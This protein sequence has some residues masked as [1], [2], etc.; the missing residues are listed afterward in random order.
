[1][2]SSSYQMTARD[3]RRQRTLKRNSVY[4]I[5]C[6]LLTQLATFVGKVS[7]LSSV[8]HGQILFILCATVGLTSLYFPI[9]NRRKRFTDLFV[10]FVFFSQFLVWI[11]LYTVWVYFLA[12]LRSLG[13]L[14]ALLALT[15]L[16]SNSNFL[17][18][19][20]ISILAAIMQIVV[21]YCAIVVAGQPGILKQELLYTAC[22]LPSAMFISYLAGQYFRQRLKIKKAKQAAEEARDALWGEMELAKKIQTSLLPVSP[23]V[24]NYEIAAFMKPAEMVGGDYYDIINIKGK[25]WITIGDVSGHGVPAGLFMMMVQ[26]AIRTILNK[27][28]DI[29]PSE[30][31]CDINTVVNSNLNLMSEDKYMTI[32][33]LSV[34]ENGVFKFSGLHQDILVYRKSTG[35]VEV[36]ATEGLWIG[37]IDEI[38]QLLKDNTVRLDIGDIILVYTDGIIEANLKPELRQN[39]GA[40]EPKMFGFRNL[41]NILRQYGE[42]SPAEVVQGILNKLHDY[43]CNDDV[44]IVSLK[45]RS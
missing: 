36:I 12:E 26:T 15:F 35:N 22:F 40:Q 39:P 31:L 19:A 25:D 1:M 30:L 10:N 33:V 6:Y 20:F 9:I 27:H 42:E 16:L 23:S 18:S 7:G 38:D 2:L 5:L 8:T 29:S 37:V 45:R 41:V 13:L 32:T 11:T 3:K 28:P 24:K 44:T 34:E 4:V 17:Q 14:F 43:T 21:A